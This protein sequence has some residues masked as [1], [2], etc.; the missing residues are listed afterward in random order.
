M[1]LDEPEL[2]DD[3]PIHPGY[4]YVADGKVIVAEY[5][6]TAIRYKAAKNIQKLCRCDA[7]GRELE[8]ML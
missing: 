3:Y 7:V 6:S 8:A 5:Q 1:K 2:E 4:L